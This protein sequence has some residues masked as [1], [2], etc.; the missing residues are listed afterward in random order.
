MSHL[1]NRVLACLLGVRIGDGMGAPWEAMPHKEIL[2][3]TGNCGVRDFC[4]PA[5]RRIHGA[6]QLELGESTDDYA[7]TAAVAYSLIRQ[8][9]FDIYDIAREHLK[10]FEKCDF[11]WGRT[12]REAVAEIKA[13]FNGQ[14]GRNPAK[15]AEA[16]PGKPVGCG[17][18]VA[19]KIAPLAIWHAVRYGEFRPEP[20][21]R[22]TMQLGLMT[23]AD[24]R[25]SY[26]AYV[27]AAL[28]A[29]IL[30]D[31][32]TASSYPAEIYDLQQFCIDEARRAEYCYGHLGEHLSG[33]ELSVSNRLLK[34][35]NADLLSEQ[36]KLLG[37]FSGKGFHAL[38][39]VPFAIVVFLRN[40]PYFG[41]DQSKFRDAMDE[42]ITSGGDT[43]TVAS[44]AGALVGAVGGLSVIPEKWREFRSEYKETLA[45][46][47]KLFFVAR[48]FV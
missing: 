10:T 9:K 40:Y 47:E 13:F 18:G 21:L 1:L 17:N 32:H 43:D 28:M 33:G 4:E 23:H 24:P 45:L 7:L 11:G 2:A 42:A 20:L 22:Q 19:M 8:R 29:Q 36:I 44:M 34:V 15:P 26:I 39:S 30:T 41:V 27:L 48:A 12:T 6:K 38:E 3:A 5:K 16:K 37:D 14:G 31:S 35:F 25:A 46:G